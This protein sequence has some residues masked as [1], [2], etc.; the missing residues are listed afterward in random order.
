LEIHPA[1]GRLAL[2]DAAPLFSHWRDKTNAERMNQWLFVLGK[3]H[4]LLRKAI[5]PNGA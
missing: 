2:G 1:N 5:Q 3:N 4:E